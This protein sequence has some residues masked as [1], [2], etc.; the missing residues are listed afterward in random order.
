[1]RLTKLK[2]LTIVVA[3]LLSGA[4]VIAVAY[5]LMSGLEPPKATAAPIEAAKVS[6]PT[7]GPLYG[8]ARHGHGPPA[9]HEV[10]SARPTA[11]LAPSGGSVSFKQRGTLRKC[12]APT[13]CAR[14]P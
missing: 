14:A 11:G 5:H 10:V 7:N 6:V 2:V 13:Q 8:V 3:P 9:R 4:C 1:M 12:D